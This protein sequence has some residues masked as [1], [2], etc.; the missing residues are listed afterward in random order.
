MTRA[1]TL[2]AIGASG[3]AGLSDIKHLL[4]AL[5]AFLNAVVMVVLHRPTDQISHLRQILGRSTQMP[6]VIAEQDERLEAGICYVGE[7]DGHLT[8]VERNLAHLID[9]PHN[10]YRNRTID[11]LFNSLA[12]HA[13]PRAIGVVLS[14]SLDD[15]AR[16]LAAIKAAGGTT[17]V[18]CE[19]GVAPS[20]MPREAVDYD[21]PINVIGSP[22]LIAREILQ[23]LSTAKGEEKAASS[24]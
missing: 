2:I 10:R 5:P 23:L 17:M 8:L 18:L 21:G 1:P 14:G 19:N 12:R 3:A 11:A 4:A 22:E 7:P 6:V 9:D 16:G 20:G 13:G 24:G 15:G